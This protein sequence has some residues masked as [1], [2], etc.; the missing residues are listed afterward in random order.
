MDYDGTGIFE[1]L[2]LVVIILLVLLVPITLFVVLLNKTK[3]KEELP[4][5]V[6]YGLSEM[7]KDKSLLTKL[8]S[9]MHI[10]CVK[11]NISHEKNVAK[12]WKWMNRKIKKFMIKSSKAG[13]NSGC[14]M[15]LVEN[16]KY[17]TAREIEEIA[18]NLGVKC[19]VEFSPSFYFYDIYLD[20]SING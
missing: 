4:Q 16:C 13:C 7:Q 8:D 19:K 3:K 6:F 12:A 20:W 11:R 2:M 5:Y 1:A 9:I 17:L 18:N 15:L 14:M 10:A